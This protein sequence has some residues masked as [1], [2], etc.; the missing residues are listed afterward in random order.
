MEKQLRN[1]AEHPQERGLWHNDSLP[2][3]RHRLLHSRF[4]YDQQRSSPD[5]KHL[6][7]RKL[8]VQYSSQ[9]PGCSEF[10][11]WRASWPAEPRSPTQ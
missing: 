2:S 1:F 10:Y 4:I 11:F 5:A 9:L 6:D 8:H 3:K 7:S